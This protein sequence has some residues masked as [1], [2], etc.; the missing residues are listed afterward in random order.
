MRSK[1]EKQRKEKSSN[2]K[3]KAVVA[4]SDIDESNFSPDYDTDKLHSE[5]ET[6][7]EV[8]SSDGETQTQGN[9]DANNNAQRI[10]SVVVA[11]TSKQNPGVQHVRQKIIM[12]NASE[13]EDGEIPSTS[14][15][16][17]LNSAFEKANDEQLTQMLKKHQDRIRRLTQDNL[18]ADQQGECIDTNI[19]SSDT[20]HLAANI[21]RLSMAEKSGE[22]V[23]NSQ[24]EDTVYTRLVKE[25]QIFEANHASG[26]EQEENQ[27][28]Q[29]VQDDNNNIS[30]SSLETSLPSESVNVSNNDTE[31]TDK[32]VIMQKFVES[33]M[34]QHSK[35]INGKQ[36]DDGLTDLSISDKDRSPSPKRK[37]GGKRTKR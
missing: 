16:S 18:Q 6:V 34:C 5:E 14:D 21:K 30:G 27:E 25:R 29:G 10:K 26:V 32:E 37:R 4:T 15:N 1:I 17:D 12:D 23:C 20:D 35:T 9:A 33:P 7:M 11:A 36:I 2:D 28:G 19:E 3:N 31:S 13:V 22:P 8:D 24:S